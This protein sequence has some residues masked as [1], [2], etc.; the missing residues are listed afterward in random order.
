[1]LSKKKTRKKKTG[2]TLR[3]KLE[4]GMRP[5]KWYTLP[6]LAK[7][8]GRG[9]ASVC[10][11][12]TIFRNLGRLCTESIDGTQRKRYRLHAPLPGT[13]PKAAPE[14]DYSR[15]MLKIE[16]L[17]I[18]RVRPHV[19]MVGPLDVWRGKSW[20]DMPGNEEVYKKLNFFL[21]RRGMLK[22]DC[23][24]SRGWIGVM[25]QGKMAGLRA[26]GLA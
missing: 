22:Y 12:L 26:R 21:W 18:E 10:G 13:L 24:N 7:M 16:K 9:E 15:P 25:P 5:E 23:H 14:P 8:T 6:G 2:P 4:V 19:A 17:P 3:E 20:R 11:M 1:M